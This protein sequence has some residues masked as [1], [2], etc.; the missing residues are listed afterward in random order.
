[1]EKYYA[2]LRY[3]RTKLSLQ[4]KVNIHRSKV[5]VGYDGYCQSKGDKFLIR[6]DN[7]LP[8]HYAIDVLIH[9]LAHVLSWGKDIEDMHGTYWGK[10]YSKVYRTFLEF[11][12]KYEH[13]KGPPE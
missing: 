13:K 5:P 2:T 11:D 8:E 9:E 6:I 12:R 10:A 4:R 1:M 3:L 7:K